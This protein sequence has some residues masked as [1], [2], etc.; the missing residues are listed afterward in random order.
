MLVDEAGYS[1]GEVL[2]L[3]SDGVACALQNG[4]RCVGIPAS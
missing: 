4:E 1:L 2:A 3:D